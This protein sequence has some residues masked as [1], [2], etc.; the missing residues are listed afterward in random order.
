LPIVKDDGESKEEKDSFEPR[1]Y[2]EDVIEIE[3]N[4]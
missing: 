3:L 2:I 1:F 4:I